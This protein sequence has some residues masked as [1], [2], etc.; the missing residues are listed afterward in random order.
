M[1]FSIDKFLSQRNRGIGNS[2][3]NDNRSVMVVFDNLARILREILSQFI[4]EGKYV[5]TILIV[6][7]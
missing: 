2:V 5:S 4:V 3:T 1:Y 6:F 7:K